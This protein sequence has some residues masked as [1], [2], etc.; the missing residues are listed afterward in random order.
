[1][2]T[3]HRKNV[4]GD[5]YVEDGC[6][7]SCDVPMVEA[8]ELFTYDIDASGSHHCYV[9]RQPSDE[10]ELDCMIKTISCAEFE[11]IHYRGRD[12]AILKRMA[13]VDA[14][15]LCDVITPA[16]PTVQRPWWRFW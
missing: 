8:P 4:P 7:T 6:C 13:D 3:P 16:P 5:F 1:M 2:V 9:S 15:H 12:D 14:S 10:S 11:C